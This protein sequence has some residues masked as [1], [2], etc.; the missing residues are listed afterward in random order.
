[1]ANTKSKSL[2]SAGRTRVSIID[3]NVRNVYSEDIQ[4]QTLNNTHSHAG[5]HYSR[6]HGDFH[7]ETD[8][9]YPKTKLAINKRIGRRIKKIR[10]FNPIKSSL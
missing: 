10:S 9:H 6:I 8:T 1:M 3:T 5:T 7:V 2:P 4:E